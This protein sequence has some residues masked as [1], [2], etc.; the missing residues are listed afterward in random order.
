MASASLKHDALVAKVKE[1]GGVASPEVKEEIMKRC[2]E[3]IK[4]ATSGPALREADPQEEKRSLLRVLE[5]TMQ[6][7]HGLTEATSP[8][9][10]CLSVRSQPNF[11]L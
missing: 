1:N 7:V 8:R 10:F 2:I 5:Y 9:P 11:V 4:Y 3:L 6:K